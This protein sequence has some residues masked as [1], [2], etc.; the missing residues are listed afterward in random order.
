MPLAAPRPIRRV[1]LHLLG[2]VLSQL[3][4][5]Q[6]LGSAILSCSSFYAAFQERPDRLI[7]DILS[8]QITE[9]TMV[10][11]FA[12][13]QASAVDAADL[14]RVDYFLTRTFDF[15]S[16]KVPRKLRF[17]PRELSPA[18]AAA[19]SKTHTVI[20]HFT[21]GF[22]HD[23][24][25]YGQEHNL[26][27]P[28]GSDNTCISGIETFRIQRALYRFQLYSTLFFRN[29]GDLFPDKQRRRHLANVLEWRFFGFFAPWINEQL[30]CI[31]DYL[32]RV[33]SR[34][35]LLSLI[36]RCPSSEP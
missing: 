19:L 3:E 20:E 36:P 29:A 21:R 16:P 5:I 28:K 13:H 25:S 27:G 35:M 17:Q 24:L 9:E 8:A 4:T 22:V 15:A 18:V 2:Q 11:A 23:T 1:P 31:H 14:R 26:L 32:D 6:S 34:G 30:A 33:L 10:Y 12:L 7:S